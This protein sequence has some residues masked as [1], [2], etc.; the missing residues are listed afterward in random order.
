MGEAGAVK[1]GVKFKSDANGYIT[2]IRFYKSAA[3]TG[4]HVGQLWSS[5]GQ[6]LATAT[7][8]NES[9]TGWQTVTFATPV[10]ITAGTTY[11]ASYLAPN[12]HFSVN[13]KAFTKTFT[14]GHLSVPTNGGVYIYGSA[15]AFPTQTN[16]SSN[17]WVDVVMTTTPPV[18]TTPPTVT[19]TTP[20]SGATNVATSTAV[21]IAFSEALNP[22]TVTTST[23]RLL[24]GTTPVAASVTYNAANNT[25]TLTPT[26]ALANSKTY[27]ISILG[28]ASGIKDAAGNALAST[29]TSAF[30]TVVT[31]PLDTTPPS[32]SGINPANGA[33]NVATSTTVIVAFS[34]ALS[35]ASVTTSTVRLLD[36][37]TQ[38]AASV[39]YN[40]PIKLSP[41]RQAPR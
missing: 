26:A 24:D 12:G 39:T 21:T 19:S 17:Y 41:S 27:T 32:V 8:T 9:S 3:N 35:S 1:L 22:A 40:A 28:G 31:P 34:E 11:V 30:T 2:G 6:L 10:A 23:I 29:F 25:V 4:T 38:V 18:D 37:T 33:T 7:F 36:G 20:A 14:S 13:R 16:Q 15:A 5:T